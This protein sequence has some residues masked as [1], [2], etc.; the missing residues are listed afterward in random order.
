MAHILE[1]RDHLDRPLRRY[2]IDGVVGNNSRAQ[3]LR[4]D[5]LLVQALFK[6]FYEEH[7]GRSTWLSRPFEPPAL[8][9]QRGIAVDGYHGPVTQ[10]LIDSFLDQ[11][12]KYEGEAILND[13]GLDPMSQRS[14]GLVIHGKRVYNVAMVHLN[15]YWSDPGPETPQP[16]KLE[17]RQDL[18]MELRAA[19]MTV[20][21]TQGT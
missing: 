17:N 19:L 7:Q 20:K 11:L 15:N 5:V 3:N 8:A 9:T 21:R 1:S 14:G 18:P 2:N 10:S 12:I 16:S 6:I 13:R 4:T